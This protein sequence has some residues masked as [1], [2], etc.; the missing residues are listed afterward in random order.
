MGE[1]IGI[2]LLKVLNSKVLD[3]AWLRNL[4]VSFLKLTRPLHKAPLSLSLGSDGQDALEALVVLEQITVDNAISNHLVCLI[5]HVNRLLGHFH[6][7]R[8]YTYIHKNMSNFST[9]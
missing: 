7:R 8:T 4:L 5:N 1:D 9:S 6:N 2:E 3:D